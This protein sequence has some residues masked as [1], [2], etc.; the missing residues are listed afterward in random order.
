MQP[1]MYNYQSWIT[2]CDPI[3]LEDYFRV[4]LN[5]AGFSVI[6]HI[7]HH[8]T[9]QGYTSLFLLGESHFAIHTFPEHQQ[10]YIELS[11]CVKEPYDNFLTLIYDV[12]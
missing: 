1:Q 11:S 5:D 9:P 8:F 3:I 2:E 4:K 7:S 12:K 6:N 10:T